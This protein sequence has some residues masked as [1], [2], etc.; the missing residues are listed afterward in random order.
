VIQLLEGLK[1]P[2][3]KSIYCRL[4]QVLAE[5]DKADSE[6]LGQAV[7]DEQS[8]PAKTLANALKERGLSLSD[9]TISKHR[10]KLC[11]CGRN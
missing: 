6:I 1:P 7:S 8:W 10:R 11:A 4:S 3:N 2:P 9:T 5:L